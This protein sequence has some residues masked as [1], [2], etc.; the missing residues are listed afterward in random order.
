VREPLVLMSL[1]LV[2][3]VVLVDGLSG[4]VLR[5]ERTFFGSYKVTEGSERRVLIHGTTLHGWE[6]LDGAWAGEPTSYYSRG[7]PIGDV[8]SAYRDT[9]VLDRVALVGL[10][11][12][13]LAA[14]GTEGQRM[15]FYEIDPVVADLARSSFGYLRASRA[16][17]SVVLGDARLSLA[18]AAGTYGLIV[19]DAFT[20]DA[21]PAHLLTGEAVRGYV[22]KLA[23]GGLL[24]V[25]VSN[26]H[27][28]LA[29]VLAATAQE[30]GL[31]AFQRHDGVTGEPASPS[32]WVVLARS[33]AHLERLLTRPGW[34]HVAAGDTRAW[35]DDY[36]SVL[37]VLDVG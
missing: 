20:S 6:E 4:N 19:L 5:R 16:D 26:R 21:I 23:P 12:G 17:V 18:R 10:G 24:A 29:P 11:V 33:E 36:S 31:V 7:G 27:L 15:D 37:Q 25:H 35:S 30:Q 3:G 14:Y 2:V 34:E 1:I 22:Q 32:N 28:D 8:M 13:T 9:A